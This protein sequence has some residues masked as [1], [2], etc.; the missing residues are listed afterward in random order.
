LKADF[1]NAP[2]AK[3]FVTRNNT[4]IPYFDGYVLKSRLAIDAK[5]SIVN[6]P[7]GSVSGPYLDGG[8]YVLA[9]KLD[10][11]VLPDSVRVRH[12]LI[13][14]IDPR[15]GQPT[16]PDSVAKKMIDTVYNPYS[17]WCRLQNGCSYV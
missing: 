7:V 12:I 6:M 9:K 1:K 15:T 13:G 11:K 8:A 4:S 2:D 16:H 17:R 14:T 10:Q 3:Q 5:D